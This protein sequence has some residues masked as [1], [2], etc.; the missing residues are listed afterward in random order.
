MLEHLRV[1]PCPAAVAADTVGAAAVA[2][3]TDAAVAAAA[4]AAA[5]AFTVTSPAALR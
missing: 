5:A 3:T 4:R 1:L 2:P